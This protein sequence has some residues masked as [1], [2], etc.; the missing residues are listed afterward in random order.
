MGKKN[1]KEKNEVEYKTL[2]DRRSELLPVMK[3][4]NTLGLSPEI[5]GIKEFY[6]ICKQYI[7]TGR[8]YSG[9][10]KLHGFKREL[11]YILPIRKQVQVSVNLKHN[12]HL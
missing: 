10:I 8:G 7:D 12:P 3:Q 2:E 4:L 1:R 9:K 11:E 6:G 5:D